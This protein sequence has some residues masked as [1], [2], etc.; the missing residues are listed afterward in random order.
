MAKQQR[1]LVKPKQ[2][3][4]QNFLIDENIIRK[5][6]S[7]FHP[8]PDDVV[9][10]VGPGNGALTA[11]LAG[12][13]NHLVTVE[14]DGRIIASLNERF[15]SPNVTIIHQD[16]LDLD[17]PAV[18]QQWNHPL[19]IIGNLPYH[20]TSPILFKCFDA[21]GVIGDLTIMVQREV[22][23]RITARVGTKAYGILS[24]LTQYYA[25]S[26]LLFQ[27]SPGCFYPK[28]KVTSSVLRIAFRHP[29]SG[30][31]DQVLFRTVV[32]TAFGKRRKTLRNCLE[33]F[34]SIQLNIPELEKELSFPLHRRAEQ[35]TLREFVELADR[36]ESQI[37]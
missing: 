34:P 23:Q 32:R 28:P 8:S 30:T 26:R 29:P 12:R 9:V 16:I 15:A 11:E 2:S 22:A 7:E 3:L 35:L 6:I 37:R 14:I 19:R 27:V 4:G 5:I 20:L 21:A 10:E 1:L 24:V 25:T 13:V 18:H 17:F 36:I 31:N 33:Y